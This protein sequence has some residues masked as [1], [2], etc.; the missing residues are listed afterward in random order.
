MAVAQGIPD[1]PFA[2]IPHPLAATEKE[3]LYKRADQILGDI[4]GILLGKG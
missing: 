4:E 2:V 1:Y 3:V